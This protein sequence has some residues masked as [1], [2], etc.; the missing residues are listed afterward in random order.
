M[1]LV[2]VSVG[3][4]GR[5]LIG[6]GFQSPCTCFRDCRHYPQTLNAS[7]DAYADATSNLSATIRA[8]IGAHVRVPVPAAKIVLMAD[9]NTEGPE[10]AAATAGHA[11]VNRSEYPTTLTYTHPPCQPSTFP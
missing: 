10:A 5:T 1:V 7:T 6:A 11:G 8:H 4:R 9:T 2:S 3:R